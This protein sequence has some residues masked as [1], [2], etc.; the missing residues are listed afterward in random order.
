MH[1]MPSMCSSLSIAYPRR[2]MRA[3]S[4]RSPAGVV[5]VRAVFRSNAAP[6]R[7]RSSSGGGNQ[8]TSAF[9]TAVQWMGRMPPTSWTTRTGPSGSRLAM[10]VTVVSRGVARLAPS[11]GRRQPRRQG[12]RPGVAVLIEVAEVDQRPDEMVG[13]AAGQRGAPHDLGQRRDTAG[14]GDRLE[15]GQAALQRLVGAAPV[16]SGA[17]PRAGGAGSFHGFGFIQ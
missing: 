13:G 1:R 2:R 6:A 3:S 4:S 15:H 9:P 5:M 14:G 7:T 8:A 10:T 16:A 11:P 17:G 12:V